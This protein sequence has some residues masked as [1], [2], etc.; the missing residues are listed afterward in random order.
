MCSTT[1]GAI[2]VGETVAVIVAEIGMVMVVGDMI[3]LVVVEIMVEIPMMTGVE[4]MMIDLEVMMTGKALVTEMG[5]VVI[6]M[7][8]EGVTATVDVTVESGTM[9]EIVGETTEMIALM[10]GDM[11]GVTPTAQEIV[12][13]VEETEMSK[14]EIVGMV[15]EIVDSEMEALEMTEEMTTAEM[16][17]LVDE[18]EVG[19]PV[20]ETVL[21]E[22]VTLTLVTVAMGTEALVDTMIDVKT[23]EMNQGVEDISSLNCLRLWTASIV[24]MI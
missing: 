24:I 21:E 2:T 3:A 11:E 22:D 13:G 12:M 14:R 15:V 5:M 23:T 19:I 7:G 6:V 1:I 20:V 9:E 8:E 17:V 10:I 4:V 18:M 16:T